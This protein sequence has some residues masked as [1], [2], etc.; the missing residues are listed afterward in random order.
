MEN[1]QK[2]KA[3]VGYKD[4]GQK[5]NRRKREVKEPVLPRTNSKGQKRVGTLGHW[6]PGNLDA[7]GVTNIRVNKYEGV[8]P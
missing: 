2:G 3:M 6:V 4:K 7:I 5:R 1:F 8:L